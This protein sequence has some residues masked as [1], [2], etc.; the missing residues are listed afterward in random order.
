MQSSNVP[1]HVAIIMDGNGRWAQN[2]GMPRV[3]GHKVGVQTVKEIVR[4]APQLGIK[5]LTLYAFSTENW[6]RPP[7]EVQALMGLL[8]TYLQSE[9]AEL[10]KNGVRLRCLGQKERLPADVQKLLDRVILET[11]ANQGLN[12]NL[13][14]NYGGRSEI[15]LAVRE[16]A[17]QCAAGDLLPEEISEEMV[18]QHL[19]TAGQPD[20]DMVIRT[21]GE[22]RLSNFLLWQSS[23][24]E[25]YITDILW[26]DFKKED[27]IRAVEY[28]QSRQRR[29]GKT[30]EQVQA[31]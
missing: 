29:F 11:A 19:S 26:P 7:K 12:L 5:V 23:Y 14:L 20:P 10:V 3:M 13:A 2:R 24:A 27:L 18:S 30:G 15:I 25:L 17:R 6:N 21:G 16:L 1:E 31:K 4:T 9:L 8:K 22:S 28:Y